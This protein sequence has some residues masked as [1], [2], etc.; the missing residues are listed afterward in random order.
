MSGPILKYKNIIDNELCFLIQ[1]HIYIAVE[2]LVGNLLE[3]SLF[4][5]EVLYKGK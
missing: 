5:E 4:I 3:N 1:S 2:I